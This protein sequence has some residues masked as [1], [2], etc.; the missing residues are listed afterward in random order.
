MSDDDGIK[1]LCQN[2]RKPAGTIPHPEWRAASS[3]RQNQLPPMIPKPGTSIPSICEQRLQIAA[4]GAKIYSSI[5]R[6]ITTGSLNRERLREFRKHMDMVN[7]HTEPDSLPEL[8]KTFTIQKFLDQLPTY[9][10]EL[11][12]TSKVALSYIIRENDPPVPLP[13]LEPQVP[14]MEDDSN[15]M[16]ESSLLHIPR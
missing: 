6:P 5:G 1:T 4:Y 8:S 14:W 9:L 15:L 10:R 11:L 13:P 12:G 3:T 7:N 2:V 16:D